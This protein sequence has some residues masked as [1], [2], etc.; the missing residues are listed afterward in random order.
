MT[1]RQVDSKSHQNVVSI[2]LLPSRKGGLSGRLFLPFGLT[3]ASG[4]TL[5]IDGHQKSA[6]LPFGTCFP[7]GCM[8]TLEWTKPMI[9]LV[10]RGKSLVIAAQS[11][12]S[13]Q[14]LSFTVP[15]KG[16]AGAYQRIMNLGG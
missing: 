11:F 14:P 10:S 9:A 1:Q 13:H 4:V 8:V 15:L 12:N 3:L 5:Q 2:E 6:S 7:A 16:F